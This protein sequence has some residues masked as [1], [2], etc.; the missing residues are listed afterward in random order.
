MATRARWVRLELRR[1][2]C[3]RRSFPASG[4]PPFLG[5]LVASFALHGLQATFGDRLKDTSDLGPLLLVG[6]A[7]LGV[8]LSLLD[9]ALWT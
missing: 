4:A 6:V 1:P 2:S 7:G 8:L 3:S 5:D 9:A